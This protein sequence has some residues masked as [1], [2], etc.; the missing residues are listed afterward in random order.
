MSDLVRVD[1]LCGDS[2][3]RLEE[4]PDDS[5]HCVVT[6]PPY[7]GLRD[8]ESEGAIGLEPTWDD[9]LGRL[10][11][12]FEQVKRVLRPD[13]TLWLNYGDAYVGPSKGG[14]GEG[15]QRTNNGTR[16]NY[17]LKMDG[18]TTK[19]L[20]MMPSRVAIALQEQGWILRSEIIW[21]KPNPMP[22]SVTDRPTN[23]HEK[24]FLFSKS[25]KY[26]YDATAVRTSRTD[27]SLSRDFRQLGGRRVHVEE[28]KIRRKR[29]PN[30]RISGVR[31]REFYDSLSD[32]DKALYGANLRNVWSIP[33]SGFPEA[34]FATF[35]ASLIEPC[36]KAGTSEKGVC[37]DCGTP[38]RRITSRA[39]VFESGSGKAGNEPEGKHKGTTQATSGEYDVRMGPK[40][41]LKTVGWQPT[42]SCYDEE[43]KK[44]PKPKKMR[45]KLQRMAWWQGWWKRARSRPGLDSW[46]VKPAT[47]LDPF[48]GAGTVGV[49]APKIGRDAMLI[50]INPKYVGIMERRIRKEVGTMFAEIN[51]ETGRTAKARSV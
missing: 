48:A 17:A 30:R 49:L 38:W 34:H 24:I 27:D 6:S 10:M 25:L 43:Y 21:H 37:V 13:G 51:C 2:L 29:Y 5:I 9:H 44:F 31:Y 33:V 47:V 12:V 39:V 28:D 7:W 14:G 32:E 18:L 23:A 11:R 46:S 1:V 26:F 45:K 22:E 42:C 8:Y 4:L 50:E 41:S 20:M 36:I 19:S 3:R 15:L 16:I 35:P 40:V